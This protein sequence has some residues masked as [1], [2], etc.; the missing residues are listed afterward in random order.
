MDFVDTCIIGGGVVGLAIARALATAGSEVLVV[1]QETLIGQGISSRN[2]EVI[3]AGIYYSSGSLKANLCLKGNQLLYEYC[4]THGV[5]Q[6]RCGKLIVATDATEEAALAEVQ[7]LAMAN[8][9]ELQVWS[10]AKVR[11]AEPQ[12]K[13]SMAL[14]SSTTGIVSAHGLMQSL[15]VDV[16]QLGGSFV[17]ATRVETIEPVAGGFV[18]LCQV[19]AADYRFGCRNLINAAGL[20]AQALAGRCAGLDASLIPPLYLCKGVYFSLTGSHP[21][22]HLIYPV[23]EKSGAGLGVHATLDLGGQVKFG[24]DVDYVDA[25]DY[26]VPAARREDY[27]EAIQRYYPQIDKTRLVP[28]YA[29]IRP[30]LQAPGGGPEDF[31]IQ[32]PG[33]HGLPGLVNL[34]GIESPGLTAAL[35][36]A[37]YVHTDILGY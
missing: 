27:F 9:V 35:A 6:Q 29:G 16:E 14:Y 5:A 23:P 34:F 18:V 33:V 17:G 13:A 36:I 19:G 11:V 24:P 8:G 20:G 3:H 30:K 7:T 37:D 28:G 31:V 2:S 26:S 22:K 1:D 25:Q 21:F 10:S 12:V 32:G 15:L 4:Q